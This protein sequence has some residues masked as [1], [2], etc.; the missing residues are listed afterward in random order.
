MARS[1]KSA[2]IAATVAFAGA[3][4]A[5]ALAAGQADAEKAI[6]EAKDAY[7]QALNVGG[8]WRDTAEMIAEA[9]KLMRAGKME[10]AARLAKEAEAQ[11]TLGHIQA[12]SQTFDNLHID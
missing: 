11:A 7:R 3:L 6:A 12:T 5:P 8:A 9:E 10:Q 1:L 4:A 2:V